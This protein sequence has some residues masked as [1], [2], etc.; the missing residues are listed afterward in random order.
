MNRAQGTS[1]AL[2][3]MR[4]CDG[5]GRGLQR[6]GIRPGARVGILAENRVEFV[7]SYFGIMRMG[8]VAVPVNH[9]LPRATIAHIFRD[10]G[11]ELALSDAARRPYVPEQRCRRSTSTAAART[12]STPFSTLG[13]WRLLYPT[14]MRWRRFCTRPAPRAYQRAYR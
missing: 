3:S 5:V 14:T 7:A 8:A 10:S 2:N 12:D 6:R 9:K 1:P 11:I 13:R 4:L